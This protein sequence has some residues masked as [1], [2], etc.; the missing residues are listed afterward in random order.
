M[1]RKQLSSLET[2]SQLY[3]LQM[4]TWF[5]DLGMSP[6]ATIEDKTALADLSTSLTT[7]SVPSELWER[8]TRAPLAG[9]K[10]SSAILIL[11]T[12]AEY[13]E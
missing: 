9:L 12:Y 3:T 4:F 13:P 10:Y 1:R 2:I 6:S 7:T 5:K 11:Q 8:N